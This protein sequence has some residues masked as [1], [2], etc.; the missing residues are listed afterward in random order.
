MPLPPISTREIA[1][2]DRRP[3]LN[4][5]Q[6]IEAFTQVQRALVA[7]SMEMGQKEPEVSGLMISSVNPAFLWVLREGPKVIHAQIEDCLRVIQEIRESL[8]LE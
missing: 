7:L 8:F 5:M 4:L 2:T 3:H 1:Q 6:A